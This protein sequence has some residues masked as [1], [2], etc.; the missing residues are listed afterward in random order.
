MK[1]QDDY[2][3]HSLMPLYLIP[4]CVLQLG[5]TFLGATCEAELNSGVLFESALLLKVNPNVIVRDVSKNLI[6]IVIL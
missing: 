4:I 5:K 6:K 2:I 3:S 1:Y